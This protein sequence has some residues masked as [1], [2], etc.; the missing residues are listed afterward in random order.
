MFF[1]I[2]W[3]WWLLIVAGILFV[4]MFGGWAFGAIRDNKA[5]REAK[6]NGTGGA[7]ESWGD[8]VEMIVKEIS[9]DRELDATS[10]IDITEL[11][12]RIDLDAVEDDTKKAARRIIDEAVAILTDDEAW[13]AYLAGRR[14]EEVKSV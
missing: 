13:L 14:N 4:A 9:Y 11:N 8:T 3:H 10:E 5:E 1:G 12:T 6:E 2:A 7:D